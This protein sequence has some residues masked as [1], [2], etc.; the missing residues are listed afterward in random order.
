[1]P[2]STTFYTR[3]PFLVVFL[4]ETIESRRVYGLFPPQKALLGTAR[5]KGLQKGLWLHNS[6]WEK[7]MYR[8]LSAMHQKHY[9]TF[10]KWLLKK[11]VRKNSVE[12]SFQA[13][14]KTAKF[15]ASKAKHARH[16]TYKS[17]IQLASQKKFWHKHG[18]K[19]KTFAFS[20]TK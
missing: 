7:S 16:I 12:N 15:L 17:I 4:C 2:F 10:T 13:Q 20:R 14:N 1:M 9:P 6:K 18:M 5:E 8:Q 11:K 19:K 3:K